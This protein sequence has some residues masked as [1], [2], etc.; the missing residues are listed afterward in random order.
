MVFLTRAVRARKVATVIEYYKRWMA[1]WPTVEALSK[2]TLDEV[3]SCWA[4]LGYYSR[5]R[6]LHEGACK[7]MREYDGQMPSTAA[8]L[9]KGLP[10]VG[11]YT[12]R[13]HAPSPQKNNNTS[14]NRDTLLLKQTLDRY[15]HP[16]SRFSEVLFYLFREGGPEMLYH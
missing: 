4:G 7:I 1:K 8:S 9:Q 6:R 16:S 10:G 11:P 15:L 13:V 2:A 14:I 5:A 12:V 3:N